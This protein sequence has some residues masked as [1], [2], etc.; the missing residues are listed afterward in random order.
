[1]YCQSVRLLL[2][3]VLCAVCLQ[4]LTEE[5]V[6]DKAAAGVRVSDVTAELAAVAQQLTTAERDRAQLQA[7][8]SGT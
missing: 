5:A 6:A 4:C 2:L 1:M 8:L 7:K 3:T